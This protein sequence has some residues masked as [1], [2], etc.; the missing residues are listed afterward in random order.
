MSDVQAMAQE[1]VEFI[2]EQASAPDNYEAAPQPSTPTAEEEA[3]A[4]GWKPKEEWGGDPED[5]ASAKRWLEKG[6]MLDT[7]KSLKNKISTTDSTLD[8]LIQN[9]KQADELTQQRT[10]QETERRLQ[11]AV[12]IGDVASAKA[13]TQEIVSIHK[14]PAPRGVPVKKDIPPIVEDFYQRNA[15]WFNEDNAENA[16]MTLYAKRRDAEIYAQNPGI[17]PE[18]E[19]RILEQDIHNKFP[20]RF[21]ASA[22]Q[23]GAHS[24]SGPTIPS[25]KPGKTSISSLDPF[26]QQM[27]KRLQSSIKNFDVQKYITKIKAQ[28]AAA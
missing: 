25:S 26:Q 9:A 4:K 1:P 6:Q 11:Q 3:R 2:Q 12:E 10:L 7:I 23:K 22:R 17:A 19:L 21:P 5:W 8:Y 16:A 18:D 13:I 20:E 24:V 15:T 27:I 14:Q 28:G